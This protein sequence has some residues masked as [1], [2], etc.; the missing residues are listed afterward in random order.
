MRSGGIGITSAV[1]R[2]QVSAGCWEKES[3]DNDKGQSRTKSVGSSPV[4]LAWVTGPQRSVISSS[5]NM[6]LGN[7][8]KKAEFLKKILKAIDGGD[9]NALKKVLVAGGKK[10]MNGVSEE[11]GSYGATPIAAAAAKGSY[12]MV[13]LLLKMGA[14]SNSRNTKSLPNLR[15]YSGAVA[16]SVKK[17]TKHDGQTALMIAAASNNVKMVKLLLKNHARVGERIS[18]GFSKQ[19][20]TALYMAVDAGKYDVVKIL[21]GKG[22]DVNDRTPDLPLNVAVIRGKLNV[23]ALLIKNGARV[24]EY[25][26]QGITPL[27]IAAQKGYEFILNYLLKKGARR[28][29]NVAENKHGMTPLIM[30][31]RMGHLNVVKILI[32]K[33]AKIDTKDRD[34]DTAL[35]YAV[36]MGRFGVVKYLVSKGADVNAQSANGCTPFTKAVIHGKASMVRY[37]LSKGAWPNIRLK[38]GMRYLRPHCSPPISVAAS[39]GYLDIARLLIKHGSRIHDRY[40]PWKITPLMATTALPG[41]HKPSWRNSSDPKLRDKWYAMELRKM[42][43]AGLLLEKGADVRARSGLHGGRRKKAFELAVENKFY[44]L[45][46]GLW[47][48]EKLSDP[49]IQRVLK[50]F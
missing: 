1:P 26:A 42:K 24:N 40:T 9:L 8:K 6:L 16:I 50:D 32:R 46:A 19:N 39:L 11:D 15:I 35:R 10:Y 2:M 37:L 49:K 30:A 31:A 20:R 28:S 7:T 33:G 14:D 34:G 27:H 29:T 47:I 21:I 45:A 43:T 38:R 48:Y 36:R 23:A 13:A 4:M 3:E 5:A 18:L 17:R 41:S 44:W 12:A 25:N 22:A